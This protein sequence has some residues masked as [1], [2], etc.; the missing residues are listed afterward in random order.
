MDIFRLLI[1]LYFIMIR[2]KTLVTCLLVGFLIAPA[3]ANAAFWNKKKK[4]PVAEKTVS[5]YEKITGSDSTVIK[6]MFNIFQDK[7]KYYFEIPQKMLEK[8]MLVVNRLT[9][10]PAELN[11]AGVNRGINYESQM[12]RFSLSADKKKIVLRQQRPLPLSP[13]GDAIH[14]AV[15]DNF[16]SPIIATFKIEAFNNDSTTAVIEVTDLYNGKETSVNNVFSNINIHTSAKSDLSRIISIKAYD[17]NVVAKSE[18]TTKVTEGNESVNVTV[19]VSSSIAL[20]PENPMPVRYDSPRI[21]YFTTSSLYFSDDQQKVDRRHFITRWRL[22]PSD[23][24]AYLQGK[25]VEPVKPIKFY[26]DS[27]T[28]KKWRKYL[29][30]G[31]TDWNYAFEKI[32][33]KNAVVAEMLPDSIEADADD[34]NYST[35]MYAASTK[36][37]A[38][39][40]STLDPRTGEILEADI[41][42]WHNVISMLQQWITVQIGAVEP[43]VRSTVIP[44]D[45]MGKAMRFVICHEVGHSLG[46]RHNMIASAAFPTDS[47]RSKSFTDKMNC[48]A[49]SVMDYAR[50]NYV[51]QPGDG[52]TKLFPNIGPYDLLAIE[53]G[54]RWYGSKSPEAEKEDLHALLDAH[55]GPLYRY[56]EAQSSRDAVDPRALSEDLGDNAMK[57]AGYGIKNL[58]IVMDNIVKWT[59]TG[60]KDQTYEEASRLHYAVINQWNNYMYHVL[61]NVGGIYLENT[62]VGDGVQTFTFVP[63]ELQRDAV[64]FLID[65]VFT[66]QKWLF[67]NDLSKYTYLYKNTPAG[68]IEYA[69]TQIMKNAQAYLFYDLLDNDRLMRMLENEFCNGKKAYTAVDLMNDM[70]K[71][72]FATTIK[73]GIPDVVTRNTQKLYVDALITAAASGEGIKVNRKLIE[74]KRILNP[75]DH[76]TCLH[77]DIDRMGRRRQISF[78]G[79]QINR[80]SD[81]ISV[82]RGELLRIKDLLKR[83]IGITDEATRYHYKDLILRIDNAL[84]IK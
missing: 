40:P 37:N 65:N 58:K 13:S 33:F 59:T 10:V 44:D 29:L 83:N 4:K 25:L 64:K 19:E 52:V 14:R 18:L 70:H 30:Q 28:P 51:A 60:E 2:R 32:G 17:N 8:D 15:A 26:I 45:I 76:S 71:S 81:A 46:L 48:T 72:I 69:P 38:M 23:T 49:A 62:T 50:Y 82:K 84:E 11:D 39:G 77:N 6:G 66:Y 73:G 31:I 41:M 21:G 24:T 53:Y 9:R 42:W 56:S 22:V 5:D 61:A 43:S 20:L 63:R 55:K 75:D 16:I 35:L 57:S 47:L 67:G 3:C 68:I 7:D 80:T 27:S 78:Y 36:M 54:Y 12:V 1:Y 74:D 79:S 34:I